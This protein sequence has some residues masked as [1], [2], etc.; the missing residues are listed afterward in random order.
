VATPVGNLGRDEELT[1]LDELRAVVASTPEA[2]DAM[3]AYLEKVHAVAYKITDADV[4][5]LKA[6]GVSEDEI[7]EQTV[8]AAISEGLRRLDAS[9]RVTK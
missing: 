9:S 1:P 8:A 2:P 7:F 5:A 6:A 3:T 4:G